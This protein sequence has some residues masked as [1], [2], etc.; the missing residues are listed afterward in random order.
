MTLLA[1]S[2]GFSV[3]AALVAVPAWRRFLSDVCAG[4]NFSFFWTLCYLPA[5]LAFAFVL[6]EYDADLRSAVKTLLQSQSVK[7]EIAAN[8]LSA[9]VAFLDISS[10]LMDEL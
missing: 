5:W 3:S 1:F 6:F 9:G 10:L 2:L 4:I 8:L 7:L